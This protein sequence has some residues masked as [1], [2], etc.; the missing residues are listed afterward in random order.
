MTIKTW[1]IPIAISLILGT[2]TFYGTFSVFGERLSRAESQNKEDAEI[3]KVVIQHQT[4]LPELKRNLEKIENRQEVFLE[5]YDKNREE[6]Q[7]V[8]RQI[9]AAVKS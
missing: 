9:L 3:N 5:K 2:G 4:L 1:V 6:D 7:R 8:F